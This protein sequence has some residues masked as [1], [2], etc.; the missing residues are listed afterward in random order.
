ML[1]FSIE[2]ST[3]RTARLTEINRRRPGTPHNSQ[4]PDDPCPGLTSSIV[5]ALRIEGRFLDC[6]TTEY[7]MTGTEQVIDGARGWRPTTAVLTDALQVLED[8]CCFL[9]TKLR[10]LHSSS[11]WK[12]PRVKYLFASPNALVS[13]LLSNTVPP[14]P[15]ICKNCSFIAKGWNL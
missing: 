15:G 6:R 13:S 5:E 10:P 8:F 9:S 4:P 2:L 7:G 12:T 14:L 11:Y 1:F 3:V